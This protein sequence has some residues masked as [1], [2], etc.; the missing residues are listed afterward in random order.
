MTFLKI[1][2]PVYKIDKWD[3]LQKDGKIEVSSEVDDL[4]EGYQNL[5]LQID[6][7]LLELN[8]QNRLAKE[9]RELDTEIRIK[10]RKLESI[11]KDIE[12]ATEH[13]EN[14]KFF[15]LHLGVDPNSSF[16]IFDKQLLLQE[17]SLTEI[18]VIS[19]SQF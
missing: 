15:L 10:T 18:E 5:K 1:S 2:L 7:L 12:K 16:L 6:K 9:A 13:C 4:S 17:S 3:S 8:A 11:L 14:L 19:D